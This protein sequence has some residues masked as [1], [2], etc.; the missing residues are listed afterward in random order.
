MTLTP[1]LNIK[2]H[3]AELMALAKDGRRT[4]QARKGCN[5]GDRTAKGAGAEGP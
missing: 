1:S 5:S 2:Q 4:A 3:I